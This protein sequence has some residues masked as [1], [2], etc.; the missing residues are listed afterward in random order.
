[1]GV[2]PGTRLKSALFG[3]IALAVPILIG[4]LAVGLWLGAAA[5]RIYIV[6]LISLVTVV[7][8]GIYS[9]NSGILSFGHLA[10][11]AVGAYASGIL[12]LPVAFKRFT[13]P[14]LPSYLMDLQLNLF[15]SICIVIILVM[16]LAWVTGKV[17]SRFDGSTASIATLGDRK[18]VV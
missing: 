7:G 9:G 15:P 5:Q 18:S 1:M 4:G 10:F 13:L 12:T 2:I 16:A 17:L 11:M 8:M 3:G 14:H 6:F